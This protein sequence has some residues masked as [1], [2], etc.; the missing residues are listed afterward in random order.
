M[1]RTST[2]TGV[3][4]NQHSHRQRQGQRFSSQKLTLDLVYNHTIIQR[5]TEVTS[6]TDTTSIFAVI[7]TLVAAPVNAETV[8]A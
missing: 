3:N 7:A 2:W 4:S 6:V 5:T 8:G 1:E